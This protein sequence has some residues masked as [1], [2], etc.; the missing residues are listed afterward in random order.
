[1][2]I[3]S[4]EQVMLY[5]PDAILVKEEAFFKRI[6]LDSRW[7]R[8]RAVREK[9][10]YLIPSQPFNWFDRPP[11]FNAPHRGEMGGEPPLSGDIPGLMVRETREF[12]RLF[13]GV[14][15]TV[16]EAREIMSS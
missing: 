8:I 7:G 5:D 10:V 6:F 16:D 13:L 12:F 15:L 2:E 3:V 9:K 4:V 14:D 11:S 1:M